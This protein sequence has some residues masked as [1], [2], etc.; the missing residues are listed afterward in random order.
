[1]HSIG[2][3]R[4][5]NEISTLALTIKRTG[6]NTDIYLTDMVPKCLYITMGAQLKA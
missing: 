2:L 4:K 1:M 6:E 3:S 5:N